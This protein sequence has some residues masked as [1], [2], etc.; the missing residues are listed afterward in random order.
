[1]IQ[2]ALAALAAIPVLGWSQTVAATYTYTLADIRKVETARDRLL[3]TVRA[4]DQNTPYVNL[5]IQID[6][7]TASILVLGHNFEL[8]R[9]LGFAI[10]KNSILDGRY[11]VEVGPS[12][13]ALVR[14]LTNPSAADYERAFGPE[15][16]A[17]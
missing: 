8:R 2:S 3:P 7:E 10:T 15:G 4:T 1:M 6:Y 9:A 14:C 12:L 5:N 17:A 16:Y 11:E 13:V